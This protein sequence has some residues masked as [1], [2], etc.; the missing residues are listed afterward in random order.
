MSDPLILA[1]ALA[2]ADAGRLDALRERH[3]PPQRNQLR[4]HVTM[5]HQL[6]GEELPAVLDA[7]RE[8]CARPAFTVEVAGVRSLG[9]GAALVLRSPELDALRA[10]LARRFTPWL[11]RQDAQRFS[12]H[13]TVANF[14]APDAAKALVADLSAGFTPWAVRAEGVAVHRYLGGPWELVDVVP[15]AGGQAEAVAPRP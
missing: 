4:A 14:L 11:T 8:A 6:P 15:L 2:G 10:D 13:V 1:L 7:V 5:F 12:A 3:F 9:R